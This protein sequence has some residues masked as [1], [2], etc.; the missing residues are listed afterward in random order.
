LSGFVMGC[1]SGSGSIRGVGGIAGLN[2]GTVQNCYSTG[3]VSGTNSVGGIVGENNVSYGTVK[4]C[5]ALNDS[6]TVTDSTPRIGRVT[7]TSIGSTLINNYA[8][9]YMTVTTPSST[10]TPDRGTSRRDGADVRAGT[11]TDQYNNQSFWQSTMGWSFGTNETSPWQWNST[12]NLPK[13]WFE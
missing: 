11:E 9:T 4:N 6:V 10:W 13:L 3:S 7:Q 8:W 5:V 2:S 12:E 1:Y